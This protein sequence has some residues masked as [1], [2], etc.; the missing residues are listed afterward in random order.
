MQPEIKLPVNSEKKLDE[1]LIDG[2]KVSE[3]N[4]TEILNWSEELRNY[5]ENHIGEFEKSPTSLIR[6]G[7]ISYRV[8]FDENR[9]FWD[10]VR[11]GSW[12]PE[13]YQVFDRYLASDSYYFDI[14]AW[15]GPTV[16]YASHLSRK[17]FAY[18][19]DPIAFK[20]LERNIELNQSNPAVSKV[21]VFQ[22]AISIET[23]NIE[24]GSKSDGGDSLSSVLLSEED[25]SWEVPSLSSKKMLERAG[26]EDEK[27]FCKID[28][29]GFEYELIPSMKSLL[30]RPNTTLYI[31]LHPQF[32]WNTIKKHPKWNLVGQIQSRLS[33]YGAHRKV[34]NSLSDFDLYYTNGRPFKSTTE[35]IKSLITGSF[36]NG[37]V[38]VKS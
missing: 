24:M 32:L 28:I 9:Q 13:T 26:I 34:L 15:I 12:E 8:I 29:E 2:K 17:A 27:V 21:E 38:A 18:E 5:L 4:G 14:G 36:P 35:L 33:F 20:E 6:Q 31:S 10:A 3:M 30:S 25:R 7:A 11:S 19:P 22:E 16:L 1:V 37:L 23:G